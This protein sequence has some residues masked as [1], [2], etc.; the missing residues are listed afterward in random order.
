MNFNLISPSTNGNDYVINFKDP[1]TISENSKVSLNWCEL[2]RKGLIVLEEDATITYTCFNNL[3][4]LKPSNGANNEIAFIITIPKGKYELT[5]FQDKIEELTDAQITATVPRL[6]NRYRSAT[7]ENNNQGQ[8]TGLQEEGKV[9]IVLDTIEL[10]PFDID[11]TDSHDA[12][13]TTTTGAVVAYTTANNTGTYDN[14]ANSSTHFD[15][16]R[17]NCPK[18]TEVM[19]SYCLFESIARPTAQTGNIFIGLVGKEYTT[20]FGTS[21]TRTNG[22]NPPVLK[23]GVPSCFV[24]IELGTHTGHITITMAANAAGDTIDKW[25]NQNQ[26][27]VNMITVLRLPVSTT[28]AAGQPYNM[29]FGMEIDNTSDTPSL[30]W[31]VANYQNGQYEE[32]FDSQPTNKNLPFKLLVGDG[33]NYNTALSRN[34]QIPF[35]FQCSAQNQDMGFKNL[36]Y[37]TI[38]KTANGNSNGVPYTIIRDYQISLSDNLQDVLN[39]GGSGIIDG[40][41]PNSCQDG[42]DLIESQ[43]DVNWKSQNFSIFINLPTNNFKNVKQQRDGGF[44]KSILANIPA[45]FTTGAINTQQ[46]SDNGLVVSTY[47]PY[48]PILSQLRNNKITTNTMEIKI[49]D[50]MDERPAEVINRSIVNFTIHDSE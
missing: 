25:T 47:Q 19:N 27:I 9:G 22:D 46:G 32:L 23:D 15:F 20:G 7:V 48:T 43:L 24:G 40:L 17:G 6:K 5:E 8:G 1:I 29:L 45:P 11:T 44:K 37:S 42:C 39:I 4:A 33:I 18:D 30:R 21:P 13:F 3:P 16:Y 14:Y 38:N 36:A 49:V 31:K 12:E 28:V 2:Q 26:E 35:G 10:L 34:S 41:H 50:M